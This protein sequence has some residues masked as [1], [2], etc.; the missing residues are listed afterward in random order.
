MRLA[1]VYCG[2]EYVGFVTSGGYG[3]AAGT[4]LVMGYVATDVTAGSGDLAVTV[5]GDLD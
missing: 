3:H 2:R 5:L 1:S 4:G